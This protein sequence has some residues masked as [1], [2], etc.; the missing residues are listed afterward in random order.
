[1]AR[2]IPN[3]SP[4]KIQFKDQLLELLRQDEST[5]LGTILSGN[6]AL[7]IWTSDG[8]EITF[9]RRYSERVTSINGFYRRLRTE[10]IRNNKMRK[11]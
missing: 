1:M 2:Y 5:K 8:W 4:R 10:I 11:Y 7:A 9:E 3:G 6:E